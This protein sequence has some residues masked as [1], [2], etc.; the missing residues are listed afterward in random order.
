MRRSAWIAG[1]LIASAAAGLGAAP[2]A[3]QIVGRPDFGP[4]ARANPFLP[5]SRPPGPS[6]AAEARDLRERIGAAREAG[7]LSRREARALDREARLI[8]RL[9]ARYG[10][11]GLSG[12][13][14][15][16]LETRAAALRARVNRPRG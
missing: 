2:A 9:S 14:R 11:D 7:Q 6:A 12:S 13:E 5:D 1:S 4:V 16:E 15:A 3:A 10:R 8:G